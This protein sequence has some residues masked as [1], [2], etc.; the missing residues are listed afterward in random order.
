[1]IEFT[2]TKYWQRRRI[3]IEDEYGFYRS[4]VLPAFTVA[5]MD[6]MTID[7]T[8]EADRGNDELY[9]SLRK[10]QEANKRKD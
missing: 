2:V 8:Q 9:R 3:Q 10:R 6:G 7:L 4:P 5:D 1:M